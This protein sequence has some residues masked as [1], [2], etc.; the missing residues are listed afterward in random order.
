MSPE[1]L[2]HDAG[3]GSVGSHP[4]PGCLPPALSL[5]KTSFPSPPAVR[6]GLARRLTQGSLPTSI[7]ICSGAGREGFNSSR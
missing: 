7:N 4:T 5:G 6:W 2:S 1:S 3:V